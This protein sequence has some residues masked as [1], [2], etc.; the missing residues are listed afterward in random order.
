M[1]LIIFSKKQN[2]NTQILC[3]IKFLL[4]KF[5]N[6]SNFLSKLKKTIYYFHINFLFV[7]LYLLQNLAILKQVLKQIGYKSCL[8][9]QNYNYISRFLKTRKYTGKIAWIVENTLMGVL[10]L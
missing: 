10:Y 1:F 6:I 5:I 3:Y 9:S 2:K 8:L 7:K 4:I